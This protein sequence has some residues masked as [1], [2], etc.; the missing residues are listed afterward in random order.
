MSTLV[1]H[2]FSSHVFNGVQHVLL[3]I[4]IVQYDCIII[5]GSDNT[6]KVIWY[7][8]YMIVVFNLW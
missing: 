3:Y 6:Q 5:L 8:A 2:L 4:Y 1:K 7:I